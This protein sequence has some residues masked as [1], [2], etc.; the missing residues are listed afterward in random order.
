MMYMAEYFSKDG[1]IVSNALPYALTA[2]V[3]CE[4]YPGESVLKAREV[5]EVSVGRSPV[6]AENTGKEDS[7]IEEKKQ[8]TVAF[9]EARKFCNAFINQVNGASQLSL[10]QCAAA[11]LGYKAF[12]S[13]YGYWAIY[14]DAAIQ[15]VIATYN[16]INPTSIDETDMD[17]E[18]INAGDAT[19]F[20]R[21]L[22]QEE[23]ERVGNELQ[24]E[25]TTFIEPLYSGGIGVVDKGAEE[26]KTP[27]T[28]LS[29][30]SIFQPNSKKQRMDD[31]VQENMKT[32]ES[33]KDLFN[34]QP[35]PSVTPLWIETGSSPKEG[36]VT[37]LFSK[38]SSRSHMFSTSRTPMSG[39]SMPNDTLSD[40]RTDISSGL[41]RPMFDVDRIHSRP[42]GY[43]N[44][45]GETNTLKEITPTIPGDQQVEYTSDVYDANE[46]DDDETVINIANMCKDLGE[47]LDF[48]HDSAFG[49]LELVESSIATGKHGIV[50]QHINYR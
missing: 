40:I 10:T 8:D 50:N 13:S 21:E 18:D 35:R 20:V 28:L 47:D 49:T 34:K 31:E 38:S 42:I 22:F 45:E 11:L 48:G 3:V 41:Y 25:D 15:Y 1:V 23:E 4:K 37:K 30:G 9:A 33:Q 5:R 7:A 39:L 32:M 17:E 36:S 29:S 46:E 27:E 44:D 6:Q 26:V 19:G 43:S 2:K 12:R 14:L 16:K 24:F